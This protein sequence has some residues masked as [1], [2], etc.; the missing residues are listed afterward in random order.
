MKPSSIRTLS[1][2][3]M[4]KVESLV[5][6]DHDGDWALNLQAV[7]AML[8]CCCC[9]TT[10][11]TLASGGSPMFPLVVHQPAVQSLRWG[12]TTNPGVTI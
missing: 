4:Q 3:I 2:T 9:L 1:S 5:R 7:Q 10:P 11:M 8:P 12:L 6:V